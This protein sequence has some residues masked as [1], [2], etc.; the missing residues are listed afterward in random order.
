MT[1]EELVPILQLAIGPVILISGVGL[2]LLSMTNRFG[3]VI[4]RSRELAPLIQNG[5][6]ET[7]ARIL[8]QVR[9]LARRARLI[10]TGIALGVV[11]VLLTAVLIIALFAAALLKL[12]MTFVII[13]C[14]TLCLLSLIGCLIC[15]LVDVNMSLH[16]LWLE[17]PAEG[18]LVE[19][20]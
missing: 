17:V 14:F 16:A 8:E 20:R 11:S 12:P 9:I 13:A 1:L 15:F 4:D 2:I 18:R 6:G 5:S 10:R 7:N 3:R 19:K